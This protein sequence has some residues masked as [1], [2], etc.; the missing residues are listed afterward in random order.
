M[1]QVS[2]EHGFTVAISILCIGKFTGSPRTFYT[3]IH[4]SPADSDKLSL[5]TCI[6]DL[7]MVTYHY[8]LFSTV[9]MPLLVGVFL[10]VV[11]RLMYKNWRAVQYIIKD[12][13]PKT[14]L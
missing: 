13:Q 8:R 2:R 10:L 1:S 3:K 12:H 4:H 14:E 7:K 6:Y 11:R 5:R 9:F